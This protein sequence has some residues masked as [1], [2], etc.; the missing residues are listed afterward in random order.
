MGG[1]PHRHQPLRAGGLLQALTRQARPPVSPQ[2]AQ[3]RAVPLSERALRK[4]LEFVGAHRFHRV[5]P[6]ASRFRRRLAH[7]R[8]VFGG[9]PAVRV[10]MGLAEQPFQ[11]PLRAPRSAADPVSD[12]LFSL[13]LETDHRAE[14]RPVDRGRD[15]AEL[16]DVGRLAALR[17][18]VFDWRV[19]GGPRHSLR[20][21]QAAGRLDCMTVAGPVAG[22]CVTVARSPT[23]RLRIQRR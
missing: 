12:A 14:V 18:A 7:S 20:V 10:T 19:W 5:A 9:C 4:G 8:F 1:D 11:R 22:V 15:K 16:R 2:V 3:R 6:E 21:G 17:V 23:W 13:T